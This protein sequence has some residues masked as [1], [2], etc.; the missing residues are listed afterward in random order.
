MEL[1]FSNISNY[2][3][4]SNDIGQIC[5]KHRSVQEIWNND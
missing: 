4:G 5:L 1:V 3:I 2:S